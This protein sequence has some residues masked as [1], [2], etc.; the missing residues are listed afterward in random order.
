M[1]SSK[2]IQQLLKYK[3]ILPPLSGYTDYPYRLILAKF[4]PPF[5][6]TEMVSAQAVI[7]KNPRTLQML[8]KVQG[9]HYNGVQLFGSDPTI[10]GKA[11]GIVENM[12]FDYIDINMG[13][14][15]KKVAGKGAGISLMK[16]EEHACLVAKSVVDSVNLP[17]TC[18]LRLG[19]TK[20]NVNVVSLSKKLMNAGVNAVVIHGRTGEKKFGLPIDFDLIKSVVENLSIPVVANGGVFTGTDAEMMIK[21]TGAA[22]VMPGRSLIGN[23]WLVS[24][25]ISVF[26]KSSFSRPNLVEKKKICLEH[27]QN[28]CDFYGVSNGV[29]KMRKI[30]PEY[31]SN[32][33][34]LKNLKLEIQKVS[35]FSKMFEILENL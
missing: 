18:K 20:Q 32:R 14:T 4:N 9:T 31:F 16:K 5:I 29:I 8:K 6:I 24:E 7:R 1:N 17:V 19:P 26:S 28:I 33:H 23:P 12:G 30:F 2:F 13:C 27:L 3:F 35:S 10:M 15:I 21:K 22:A 34:N 25:L 11:A